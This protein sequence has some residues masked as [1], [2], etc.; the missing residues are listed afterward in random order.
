MMMEVAFRAALLQ[1]PALQSLVDDRVYPVVLPQAVTLPAITYQIATNI[2]YYSQT[3]ASRLASPRM[4]VDLYART[5]LGVV[6][7]R[8]T[9]MAAISGLKGEFGSP[10]VRLQGVFRT[11]ELD[12]YEEQLEASGPRMWRKT[13]DFNVWFEEH[14]NG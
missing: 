6:Q 14:Y 2:S 11:M 7:L 12:A 4:Q 8:D 3:G 13:L 10:P 9:V 5:H 1:S